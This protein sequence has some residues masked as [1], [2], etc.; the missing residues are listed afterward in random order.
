MEKK[1]SKNTVILAGVGGSGVVWNGTLLARAG[2]KKYRYVT[3]FPNFT[4]SMRGGLCECMIILSDKE[5]ACPLVARGD[6]LVVLENS[7]LKAFEGRVKPEGVII[8]ESTGLKA[9][10]E[11][12]DVKVI[13]IPAYEM[14]VK[15]G[16]PL[17]FNLILLG[18]YVETTKIF[19]PE[20]IE[21]EIEAK[22]GISETGV[23]ASEKK[24]VLLSHNLE[25]FR[26]GLEIAATY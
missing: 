25:A 23:S 8:I 24:E 13:K 4:T 14:A 26:R 2:K 6:A 12:K 21:R 20:F 3:R 7:Q 10:V 9:E 16:N 22:F 1:D 17:V 15:I 5:I 11:R 19:P 18:A